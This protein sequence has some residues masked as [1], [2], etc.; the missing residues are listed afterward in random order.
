MHNNDNLRL[1]LVNETLLNQVFN[2]IPDP[3]FVKDEWQRYVLINQAFCQVQG[4]Q[5]EDI[6][7]KTDNELYSQHETQENLTRDQQFL[8][9]HQEQEQQES[10]SNSTGINKIL[11]TQRKV[12]KIPNGQK[13]LLGIM[14]KIPENHPQ[15]NKQKNRESYLETLVEIQKILLQCQSPNCCYNDIL[16]LLGLASGASRVY[17]FQNNQDSDG[18]LFMSQQAEWCSPGIQPEID[19]PI[20]QNLPYDEFSTYFAEVLSRGEVI[21][22]LVA[23]LPEPMQ[24]IL[25]DQNIKSILVLPLRVKEEFLGF[26]GFDNCEEFQVWEA[27]EVSLLKAAA[28]AI[29]LAQERWQT[30]VALREREQQY[31]CIVETANEGIWRLDAEH[32]LTFANQRTAQLLGYSLE[33]ILGQHYSKF[34]TEESKALVKKKFKSRNF[35]PKNQYDLKLKSK[36]GETI[37]AMISVTPLMQEGEYLGSLGMMLDVTERYQAEAERDR[38]FTLSPDLLCIADLNGYFKRLNPAWSNTLGYSIEELLSVPYLEFVHPEDREASINQAIEV[39]KG[40]C[41]LNFQNRYRNCDGSYRWLDWSTV[42]YPEEGL[43]YAVARDITQQKKNQ[44]ERLKAERDLQHRVE[45]ESLVTSIS[46]HF[47]NLTAEEID[48]GIQDTLKRIG[49]F[50][51]VDRSYVIQINQGRTQVSNTHEWCRVGIKPQIDQLQGVPVAA[52]PWAIEKLKRFEILHIPDV[53]D[54]PPEAHIDQQEWLAES[55]QSLL[56]VPMVSRG[57]LFGLVGFDAVRSPKIWTEA[58]LNLLRLVSEIFVSALER[59]RVEERLRLTQFAIDRSTDAVFWVGTD[60]K[61]RYVNDAACQA[62][63]YSREQLLQMNVHQISPEFPP[64]KWPGHWEELKSLRALQFETLHQRADSETFPVEITANYLKFKNQELNFAFVRDI[65]ERKQAEIALR[66]SEQKYRVLQESSSDAIILADVEGNLLEANQR[67]EELLGYSKEELTSM[68]FTQIHPPHELPRVIASFE[69][70]VQNKGGGRLEDTL[71]L[72]KDGKEIPVDIS[73]S[74]SESGGKLFVQGVFRD[75]TERKQAE[76]QLRYRLEFEQLIAA[77]STHFINLDCDQI[78]QGIQI[79]LQQIGE[80]EKVDRS[81]VFQFSEDGTQMSNTQEWCAEGISP[82]I[83]K[84]QA[85]PS[86]SFPWFYQKLQ[87]FEIIHIPR[88]DNL[89]PEAQTEKSI[90]ER[91]SIKSLICVPVMAQGKL[92]GFVGFDTVKTAKTWTENSRTLLKLVGEIFANALERKRTETELRQKHEEMAAVFEAFPDL[93]FRVQ[94]DGIIL[95]Y[96]AGSSSDLYAAPEYF[97]GQPLQDILPQPAA[98]AIETAMRQTQQTKSL[99]C[100]EY[101]L[102]FPSGDQHFEARFVPFVEKQT[103][104]IVRNI[105]VRKRA[106]LALHESM[107]ALEQR[108]RYLEVLVQVQRRLLASKDIQAYY[109]EIIEWLGKA[110]QASR[111]YLFENHRDS[112]G[113]L[114]MSQRAEWCTPGIHPEIDNP[115][116]QNLS[117]NNFFPRWAEALKKG[118]II[119]GI[120]A[121]FPESERDILE[122]QNIRSILILPITVSGEFWGFIGF[123]HCV[124]ARKWDCL[125]VGLLNAAASAISLHQERHQAEFH[126]RESEEKFRQLAENID[127]VFWMTDPQKHHMIYVSPAYEKIWGR[128]CRQLYETPISFI[129]AIHPEDRE[130]VVAALA[131]QIQGIYDE[132]YRVI[133]PNGE[134]R[135]IRDRAFPIRNHQDQV[136]R[137]VGLAEDIS[138][139]KRTQESLRLIVEGTASKIGTE[140]FQS[141]VRY[142]A[143]VLQMRYTF[144]TQFTDETKTC[145]RTLAFWNEN[146]WGENFEYNLAG[147]PCAEVFGNGLCIYP[148][149]VQQ[150]FPDDLDLVH[151][152]VESYIGITLK[153]SNHQLLG[154]LAVMDVKPMNDPNTPELIIKIFAARAGAEL[155]RLQAEEELRTTQKRLQYL[156][157]SS[158]AMIYTCLPQPNYPFTFV[159]DNIEEILG[160]TV[161]QCLAEPTTFWYSRIHPEDLPRIRANFSKLIEQGHYVNEYRFFHQDGSYRW[162]RDEVKVVRSQAGELIELIGSLIEISDRKQAEEELSQSEERLQLALEGSDLGLWDWHCPSGNTYFSSEWKRMLGYEDTDIED[163]FQAWE[164]LVHSEDLP[165]TLERINAHLSGQTSVYKAEFRMTTKLGDWKWILAHGKVFEWDRKGQPMRMT[166]TH[167]DIS[168][169]KVIEQM[170]DEFISVISHE[171][172]TPMTSIHASLKLL[173][174]GRLGSLNEK[175][176][177]ML[178]IAIN[179]TDRLSRLINDIL[180]LQRL[181]SNEFNL[182]KQNCNGV[183]L[184]EQALEAMQV[185]ADKQEITLELRVSGSESLEIWA[186]PDY[187]LQVLT[188]LLNN[189]IKFSNPHSIIQV[190]V[191]NRNVDALFSVKDQGRGIPPDKL[192]SIFEKFQQVDASDSRQK[193]GT[194]LGLAI[195]RRIIERHGGYIWVESTLGEGSTF[196]F[197]CQTSF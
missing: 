95:D 131:T 45:L 36:S 23:D 138:D 158:P 180:D 104:A 156:V 40:L 130:R 25:S 46:T 182:T 101:I 92:F 44:Q 47:I 109:T 153:D 143:E 124:E 175:G 166:G 177:R 159:S 21:S 78:D 141:L 128:T 86:N 103:I 27:S 136:Y 89:P 171:L 32:K 56:C 178:E 5:Q 49:E 186:N 60:A 160:Y 11:S 73:C 66:E 77:I 7:G 137:V 147:T 140:F 97:L 88:I 108:E 155:E 96:K 69:E 193:G 65:R 22:S 17:L 68:H 59:K 85:L 144:I 197:T 33:E 189:A 170:K 35:T 29:S 3:I 187:I 116:L 114:L 28:A 41:L 161:E 176:N 163:S 52:F 190:C 71:V 179:N 110:S 6:I 98:Q 183:Q 111:V 42:P 185:I 106:E 75:I 61:F 82:Q 112:A 192:E 133:Q 84:L 167:K 115:Q 169:R 81:Y 50:A 162:L 125:E 19:N 63:G 74:F 18:R 30:E 70:D 14:R 134:I 26:I 117:Y 24:G 83:E 4:K 9:S 107:A 196:Y 127:S 16:K 54:L 121:D 90:L 165:H 1:N 113:N 72:S 132:E 93:F 146:D 139:R 151:L 12:L 58:S 150:Q 129:N 31:R 37:L 99:V 120:V 80:F 194:G 20:Y 2:A 79:A 43:I 105:S 157:S 38:F 67:A 8:Q 168:E 188:N 39:S 51:G 195:C 62:L 87:Q 76:E 152:G 126:L 191:E 142:L 181:E 174:T 10:C 148:R 173:T 13:L 145:V 123:D 102:P 184:I 64:E 118:E 122:P 100:V 172:R 53:M 164:K 149:A 48:Q 55:I 154:H 34:L 135:W 15:Q 91:Q 119:N 94:S 57:Q